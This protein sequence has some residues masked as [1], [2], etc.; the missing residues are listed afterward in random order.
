MKRYILLISIALYV[1]I[2]YAGADQI[3][4]AT[5]NE[6]IVNKAKEFVNLLAKGDFR[7]AVN[8]FDNTMKSSLTPQKLEQI[9]KSLLANVGQFKEQTGIRTEKLNQYDVIYVTCKFE[10]SS[11]DMK[12]IF[13]KTQIAGLWFVPSQAQE[14]YNPPD[15][16]KI[17]SFQD[18]EVL[19]GT[20][21][22]A[23]PGSLSLPAGEGSFPAIVLV[24]GSGPQDRDETIGPNKPF[25]DLAWGLA[26]KGIAV[27][28]YEKRTKQYAEKL[29]PI[30]ESITVKEEVIDDVISAVSF[31]RKIE[32]INPKRIF[33][34][35]HS[36]GGMLIPRIGSI[37]L[38]I[39][40][41]VIM[42]GSTKSLENSVIDQ[43]K[44]IFSLDGEISDQEKKQLDTLEKQIAKVKD[45]NLSEK[46]PSDQLLFN[47]PAKY[48][49]D[50]RSYDPKEFAKNLKQP[51]L[52]LQGERD[53]QVTLDDFQGWKDAFSGREN[54]KFKTYPK[55]NHLFIEGKGKI[56][57]E[58]YQKSGHVSKEVIDD[59][60]DWIMGFNKS[61]SQ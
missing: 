14:E 22:F 28:R 36:L 43:I 33:V 11:L 44:Y 1:A 38:D 12:I 53:Y 21:E 55:L 56:T 20:G 48:W 19:I 17:G 2:L 15:Y 45:P 46:T 9:W 18:Q 13:D 58:E 41:F 50:L 5:L 47:L 32:K 49:L 27:L 39:A 60:Y 54:V 59:V 52:V 40:G 4:G 57:P 35:G 10:M 24:H 30:K 42:A 6:D 26:S 7:N 51:V 23:L 3:S 37:D 61:I 34:L 8:D 29:L 31:L 25:R 16:V